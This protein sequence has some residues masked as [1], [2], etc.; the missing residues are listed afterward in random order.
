[1]P[2][3]HEPDSLEQLRVISSALDNRCDY[4]I[5]RNQ[6]HSDQ[7]ALYDKSRIRSRLL[8]E[9][10]AHEITMPKLYDWLVTGL[11]EQ[12]I[13]LTAA[14][15]PGKFTLLDRQRLLNW[16]RTL[17][18]QMESAGPVLIPAGSEAG[19]AVME[20]ARTSTEGPQ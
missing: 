7:F 16:W 6:V 13:T 2:V 10:R 4:V 15:A 12:N 1:M 19:S 11:S 17:R 20:G 18:A 14:I 5:V 9:L 3:N 8:S